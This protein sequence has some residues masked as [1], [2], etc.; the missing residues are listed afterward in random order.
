MLDHQDDSVHVGLLEPDQFYLSPANSANNSPL[1]KN[2]RKAVMARNHLGQPNNNQ[3]GSSEETD[4]GDLPLPRPHSPF[5]PS[6]EASGQS[7]SWSQQTFPVSEDP[8][9]SVTTTSATVSSLFN[10]GKAATPKALP[11]LE[12]IGNDLSEQG[13][14][15]KAAHTLVQM[16]DDN[17]DGQTMFENDGVSGERRPGFRADGGVRGYEND[18]DNDEDDHRPLGLSGQRFTVKR[19]GKMRYCQKC[20]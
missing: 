8:H 3:S 16:T 17:L 11:P 10:N 9:T 6:G 7:D 14:G 18:E 12:R 2:G 20:K 5:Y 19:D 13:Q 4:L 15:Q 1:L